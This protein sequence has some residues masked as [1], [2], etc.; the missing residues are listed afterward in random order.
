MVSFSLTNL[1][2]LRGSRVFVKV[3]NLPYLSWREIRVTSININELTS[4]LML[5][6]LFV[7]FLFLF[8]MVDMLSSV[9]VGAVIEAAVSILAGVLIGAMVGTT[10]GDV[11]N[12]AALPVAAAII[13]RFLG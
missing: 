6:L 5:L 2:P 13:D 9:T 3:F 8:F 11:N 7:S 12:W 1:N 10:G 4:L